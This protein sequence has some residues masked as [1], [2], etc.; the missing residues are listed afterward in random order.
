MS[1]NPDDDP[2][3]AARNIRIMRTTQGLTQKELAARAGISE[4]T[5]Y[6]AE[7]GRRIRPATFKKIA[8]ALDQNQDE[9]RLK[10]LRILTEE[11]DFV[12]HRHA[13]LVWYRR[14]DRRK[15][16]PED[17]PARI[18]D[19]AER[20]RLGRLGLVPMFYATP[21]FVMAD[22]PGITFV[23]LY[24]D[25]K[26]V[27]SRLYKNAIVYCMR[28]QVRIGLG[29]QRTVLTE[30]DA[31]GYNSDEEEMVMGPAHPITESELPPLVMW[32]GANRKG[33]T[34]PDFPDT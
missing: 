22:G 9:L 18:Q 6:Y 17:S 16:V 12:V 21:T 1:L 3:V 28:G 24:E 5:L 11:G 31:F 14:D 10:R 32:I 29:D 27:N 30:G 4:V 8:A 7:S 2:A 20:Q 25:Y 34:V 15:V 23:E 13:N 26:G 19:E 33:G